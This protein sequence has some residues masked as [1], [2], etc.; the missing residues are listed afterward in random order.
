MV[1]GCRARCALKPPASSSAMGGRVTG[2]HASRT[3][4]AC[5]TV[6]AWLLKVSVM[7]AVTMA[8]RASVWAAAVRASR[9]AVRMRPWVRVPAD[10]LPES[11]ATR[12]STALTARRALGRRRSVW[13]VDLVSKGFHVFGTASVTVRSALPP[14]SSARASASEAQ[15]KAR[16]AM[17]IRTA[18]A[19]RVRRISKMTLVSMTA[20][21]A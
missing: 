17:T 18:P 21:A 4:T 12:P 9:C 7:A 1:S 2:F 13:V 20:T 16:C 3:A 14:A 19:R 8:S 15:A 5:R 6:C 11:V 10:S